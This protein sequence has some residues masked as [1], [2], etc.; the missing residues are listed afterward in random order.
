MTLIIT[1]KDINEEKRSRGRHG[2]AK[3]T[4]RVNEM[5]RHGDRTTILR[6]KAITTTAPATTLAE[7]TKGDR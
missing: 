4:G 3:I 5:P 6:K 1:H 2:A 7:C